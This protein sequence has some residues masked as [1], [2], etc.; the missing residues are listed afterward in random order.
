M[1]AD[2]LGHPFGQVPFPQPFDGSH[3]EAGV[4]LTDPQNPI[5]KE[6]LASKTADA[7]YLILV[8]TFPTPASNILYFSLSSLDLGYSTKVHFNACCKP[9]PIFNKAKVL[10]SLPFSLGPGYLEETMQNVLQLLLDLCAD[11]ASALERIP[12]GNGVTFTVGT[13]GV[14]KKIASPAKLSDYW[15]QLYNCASVLECCENFLS[16]TK[17]SAPCLLCHPFGMLGTHSLLQ[18]TAVCLYLE[19][20]G[21]GRQTSGGTLNINSQV[22]AHYGLG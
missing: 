20:S 22:P 10:S 19:A 14:C 2:V 15:R 6:L 5:G 8:I 3:E 18:Q 4:I 11:P 17:P 7:P 21:I 16:A 13:G 9:S 1:H 12:E